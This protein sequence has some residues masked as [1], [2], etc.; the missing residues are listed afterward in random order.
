MNGDAGND[1]LFGDGSGYGVIAGR[2][3][4]NAG[5]DGVNAGEDTVSGGFGHDLVDGQGGSDTLSGGAGRDTLTGGDG[6]DTL[7][8][9]DGNDSIEGGSGS[10]TTVFAG[11]IAGYEI[12][13]FA[14]VTT[15]TDLDPSADGDDGTDTLR[16]VEQLQFA[17]GVVT[18]PGLSSID[19]ATLTAN[20]GFV[21]YGADANDVSGRSVSSAGDVNG[22]GLD[23]FIIG[24]LGGDAAGNTKPDAGESYVIFGTAEGF[25]ASLDLAALTPD[26]GFVIYGADERRLFGRVRKCGGGR[27]RR[28]L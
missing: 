8:G 14:G 26:Q 16:S 25:G 1:T 27:E 11:K 23:D 12:T 2:D 17:D 22:D 28:R 3:G 5:G 19:L 18:V 15:V 7:S 10:D 6:S 4:V 21:I 13:T 20:Q 24:A 9:G